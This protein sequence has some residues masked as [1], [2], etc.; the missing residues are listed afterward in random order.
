[1]YT[2]RTDWETE[3]VWRYGTHTSPAMWTHHSSSY[4]IK[5]SDPLSLYLGLLNSAGKDA[6]KKATRSI[7]KRW[8]LKTKSLALNI[9]VDRRYCSL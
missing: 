8:A 2:T 5:N 1:M 7:K 9:D 6:E 4:H 3:L